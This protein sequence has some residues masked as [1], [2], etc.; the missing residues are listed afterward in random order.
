MSVIERLEKEKVSAMKSKITLKDDASELRLAVV[1]SALAA[2]I[3]AETSG[4]IRKELSDEEAISVL[5][6]AIKQRRES[7]EIYRS[8]SAIERADREDAEA[9]ILEEFVPKV[10]AEEDTR[11]LV[12]KLIKENSLEGVQS[13]GKLMSLIKDRT[14][15]DKSIVSK[16][17]RELL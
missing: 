5:R 8:S 6:K 3:A 15:L 10:L 13:M 4:K 9:D 17:A 11:L 7:A 12:S 16:V 1:R 2:L 14:D